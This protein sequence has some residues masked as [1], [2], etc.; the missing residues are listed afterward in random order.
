MFVII[1]SQV[2]SIYVT[3][4]DSIF[5]KTVYVFWLVEGNFRVTSDGAVYR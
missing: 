3:T 2:I 5:M 1:F 4:G